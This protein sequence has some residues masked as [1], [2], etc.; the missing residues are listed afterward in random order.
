[1]FIVVGV[2]TQF[3]FIKNLKNFYTFGVVLTALIIIMIFTTSIVRIANNGPADTSLFLV[4]KHSPTI[5]GKFCLTQGTVVFGFDFSPVILN[6]AINMKN[7]SK[8]PTVVNLAYVIAAISIMAATFLPY[9]AYG[10]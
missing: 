6:V 7:P 8:F 10:A 9:V 2:L 5:I 4:S 1:M 3:R